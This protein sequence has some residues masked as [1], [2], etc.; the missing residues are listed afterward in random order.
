M[1]KTVIKGKLKVT[2][3]L[4]ILKKKAECFVKSTLYKRPLIRDAGILVKIQRRRRLGPLS[5]QV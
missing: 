2:M 3:Y 1:G 4:F 5:K